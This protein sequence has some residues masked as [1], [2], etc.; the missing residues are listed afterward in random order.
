[1]YFSVLL[2][3]ALL[4][5][6]AW[7]GWKKT[8]SLDDH[9]LAGRAMPVWLA[10]FTLAATLVGTGV[11]LGVVELA[12]VH[13]VS[14]MLYPLILA[15]TLA[16]STIVAAGRFRK[17][18]AATVPELMARHYGKKTRALVA[19]ASSLKWIGPTA[20]QYLAVGYIIHAATGLDPAVAI[21]AGGVIIVA[22][23]IVGGAWAIAYTDSL[24]LVVVYIG[25][26]LLFSVSAGEHGAVFH[27]AESMGPEFTDWSGVG[28]MKITTWLGTLLAIGFADQ[29]WLQRSAMVRTPRDAV[30]SGL[31]GAA[32]VI[33]IGYFTVYAG[34]LAAHTMPGL[35]PKTAAPNLIFASFPPYVAALFVTAIVAAA[36]SSVDSWLHSSATMVTRDIYLE[37]I[38]PGADEKEQ[39]RVMSAF[40][41]LM[42]LGAV[43]L[44]LIWKGAIIS[45]VFFTLVWGTGIYIGPLLM[46]WYLPKRISGNMAFRLVAAGMA[47]GLAL[48]MLKP[49]GVSP[50]LTGVLFCYALSAAAYLLTAR[51]PDQVEDK[52]QG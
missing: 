1:M 21:I 20:A 46:V 48:A 8:K 43:G 33:P 18:G 24:Q 23:V 11:T 36:M 35:D 7:I 44:A 31:A 47:G 22:Y 34:L 3:I 39:A 2:Y 25:F 38:R 12:Y 13:G 28:A 42:G 37:F 26:L 6:V 41:L 50:I 15:L 14:A 19:L 52:R 40:T 27:L 9:I 49:F 32:M 51:A 4:A 30:V 5:W 10:S 45:L 16:V 17:S 29:A